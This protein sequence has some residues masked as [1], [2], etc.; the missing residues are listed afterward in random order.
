MFLNGKG[1]LEDIVTRKAN[2][3]MQ[4]GNLTEKGLR[5]LAA[6][7]NEDVELYWR[8]SPSFL[9]FSFS[10]RRRMLLTLLCIFLGLSKPAAGNF[11][12][13]R[14]KSCATGRHLL[15]VRFSS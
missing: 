2:R 3:I 12:P 8:V 15:D 7:N 6:L 1:N 14:T 9:R 11:L 10:R 4:A 13:S 5:D